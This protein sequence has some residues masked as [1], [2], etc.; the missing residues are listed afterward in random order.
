MEENMQQIMHLCKQ[1]AAQAGKPDA[2]IAVSVDIRTD[3]PGVMKYHLYIQKF[4]DNLDPIMLAG[5]N[6]DDLINA[7][8][9]LLDDGISPE[10]IAIESHYSQ[11]ASN[12][13]TIKHHKKEIKALKAKVSERKK[14]GRKTSGS[15]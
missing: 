7:C 4:A 2:Y 13:V 9:R 8:Q 6:P 12:E 1:V 3:Q 11:I 15:N 10:E 5:S 14:S